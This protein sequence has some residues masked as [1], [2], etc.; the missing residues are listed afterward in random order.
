MDRSLLRTVTCV[1]VLFCVSLA[2]ACRFSPEAIWEDEEDPAAWATPTHAATTA[3]PSRQAGEPPSVTPAPVSEISRLEG[4]SHWLYLIDVDLEMDVVER[5]ASSAHD[6]VVLDLIS[7]EEENADYPMAEVVARLHDAPHPK[8][9][10]AYLDIGQAEEYRTYWREGWKVGDPEWIAGGDPDGWEG[11]YPVAYWREE[12]RTIWLGGP[13]GNIGVLQQVLDAGFDGVYLDWVEAYSDENV[14][15]LAKRDGVDA[16]QEMIRW[17]GDI[18]GYLRSR[19]AECVVIGQNAAELVEREDYVGAI[20]ALA[21]EQVWFDGGADNDPPG[22]CPLPRT[23]ADV[24]TRAYR[25][26]LSSACRKVHDR[27][28]DSTLHVSSEEFLHYLDL[29]RQKGLPVLTV[30]Y[31]LQPENVAWVYETSRSL[32][33]V[34]FVGSRALDRYTDP[35]P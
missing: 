17:V 32:G 9:V 14:A 28:P 11:N 29:A 6:M 10:L 5:I 27:Y 12:W 13:G 16:V 20:D 34:P 2:A 3:R 8:L 35:V 18:R 26:S 30:D 24:E 23:G 21:Q 1:L 25:M 15:A 19:C 22:D 7:S 31:A 4:V 33:Y